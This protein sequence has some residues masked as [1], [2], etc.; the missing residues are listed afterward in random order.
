MEQVTTLAQ[1]YRDDAM[2]E[3]VCLI[4]GEHIGDYCYKGKTICTDCMVFIR[5]NC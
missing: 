1:G 4:C 3:S 5:S 2:K